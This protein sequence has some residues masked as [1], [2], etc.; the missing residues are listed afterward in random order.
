MT[1]EAD[2]DTL[3]Y[4]RFRGIA[5]MAGHA[6]GLVSVENDPDRKSHLLARKQMSVT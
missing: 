6:A 4:F 5:D 2:A 1:V 3:I